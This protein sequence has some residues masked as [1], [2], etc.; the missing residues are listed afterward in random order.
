MADACTSLINPASKSRRKNGHD[1]RAKSRP[2]APTT[3]RP[4]SP[5]PEGP[6]FFRPARTPHPHMQTR[7]GALH[8]TTR[9]RTDRVQRHNGPM[10]RE[11]GAVG[12]PR[13]GGGG[14]RTGA[15]R[16]ALAHRGRKW[17]TCVRLRHAARY[18]VRDATREDQARKDEHSARTKAPRARRAREPAEVFRVHVRGRG[19]PG[20]PPGEDLRRRHDRRLRRPAPEVHPRPAARA[21]AAGPPPAPR[22]PCF[23]HPPGHLGRFRPGSR[24]QQK[25]S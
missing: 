5:G 23:P 20:G 9:R 22:P 24:R 19:A 1:P 21:S 7:S 25:S 17:R 13:P 10:R 16:A 6:G 4:D 18:R 8:G 15:N 2:P 3:S 12:R 11:S 14:R